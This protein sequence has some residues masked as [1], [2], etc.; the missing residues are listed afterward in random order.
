MRA[1]PSKRAWLKFLAP[2]DSNIVGNKVEFNLQICEMLTA[3]DVLKTSF[4]W[5]W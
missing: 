1:G 5:V 2:S 3:A 4:V